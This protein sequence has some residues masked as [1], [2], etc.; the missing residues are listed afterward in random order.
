LAV[1][2]GVYHPNPAWP[3][4]FDA[5]QEAADLAKTY[6]TTPV[7]A[8]SAPVQRLLEGD[9]KADLLHFAVHGQYDPQGQ[10]DGVVLIDGA[11]SPN[12]VTG[13]ELGGT[14]FVFLNACQVGAA[15]EVLGDYAGMADAF[16]KAGA[17]AVIA[18]LWSI[19]DVLARELALQFYKKALNGESPAS[20]MRSE[21]T[22]FLKASEPT[23]STYL[24]YQFYGHPRMT[25]DAAGAA[26]R[27]RRARDGGSAG[28]E[29]S[30]AGGP[31]R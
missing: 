22:A 1:V 3:R 29:G 2:W 23:S 14:P 20:V 11:L 6:K 27:R 19:D 26:L 8:R 31:G 16:L 13:S 9:P 17:A 5:E 12:Q 25:L 28:A 15:N 18:P 24:A 10:I 30:A 4:L 7:D 21:R